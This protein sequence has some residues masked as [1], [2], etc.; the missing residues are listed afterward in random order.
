MRTLE[1]IA[2]FALLVLIASACAAP[3]ATPATP[4]FTPVPDTPAPSAT[5]APTTTSPPSYEAP[6]SSAA[7]EFTT[8]FSQHTVP[9]DQVSEVLPKDRIPALDE[10]TFVAVEEGDAWLVSQEPVLAVQIGDE[11]HAY[12]LQI[13]MWH[14]IV[15]DVID[16][17]P[18]A[19]TYCPLCN[20]AI[21]FERTVDWQVLDFGT[22][23]RLR[24]SNLIMYDRQTESWWQQATGE[25]IAG[26]F[27]SRQLTFAPAGLIS[28]ADFKT[29][30]PTGR[31]LSRE[32]GHNRD[33]GQNP[34]AGYDAEDGT[35]F[36]YDGPAT[37]EDLPPMARVL[38][39]VLDGEAVA[40]PYQ[41]L[42]E[43]RVANDAV[44]DASVVVLWEPGVASAM[45]SALIA[46]GRDVGA[47]VAFERM[48]DG[49]PLTFAFDDERDRFIDEQ[50][51]SAWNILGQAVD[52]P[53]AGRQLEPIAG[54]N[55][56]W[57]SWAVFRPETRVY[58]ADVT[59][60]GE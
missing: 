52:G 17:I 60:P 29:A 11:A 9:Y 27:T 19:A 41:T 59:S 50:T 22:T 53:S 40:Y 49:E 28:W 8:D 7:A 39:V 21:A 15:N 12:P 26:Q 32:T 36:L 25:A 46:D 30:Y 18:V 23:G 38:G 48:L 47:A 5:P 37:P 44:G 55:N 10:P 20:T 58:N 34:Y 33:Y 16:G 1:W 31:V 35:P 51:G 24:Y 42:R 45:D 2:T 4:E 13:L 54:L 3:T 56:F 14:E 43:V 57:F 6:S